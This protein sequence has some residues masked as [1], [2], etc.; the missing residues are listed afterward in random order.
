VDQR[1]RFGAWEGDTIVSAGRR[2][3]LTSLVERK[4]GFTLLAA[5]TDLQTPTVRQAMQAQLL[6]LPTELR[7][8]ATFDNGKE[9]ADQEELGKATGLDVYFAKP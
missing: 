8:T 4:S 7:H 3:G 6:E 1:L 2:G 5:V 9:F